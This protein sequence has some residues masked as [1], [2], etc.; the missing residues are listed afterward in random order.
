M[1]DYKLIG[2]RIKTQRQAQHITQEALA[3]RVNVTPVYLSKIENG[4]V[5]PTLDLL[6]AVCAALGYDLNALFSGV[7]PNTPDYQNERVLEL[8]QELAPSVK[9]VALT[10]LEQLKTIPAR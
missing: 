5:R 8:F 3:E 6:D 1:I 10:L 4:H 9:P 7:S 2:T